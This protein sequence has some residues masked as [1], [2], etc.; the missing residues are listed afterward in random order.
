M[1]WLVKGYGGLLLF[2]RSLAKGV[3]G[4]SKSLGHHYLAIGSCGSMKGLF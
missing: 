3:G 4:S 2:L 1:A